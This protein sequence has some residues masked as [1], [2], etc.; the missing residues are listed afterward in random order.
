M[1]CHATHQSCISSR[2]VANVDAVLAKRRYPGIERL[3]AG[4][5]IERGRIASAMD[6]IPGRR[7]VL[8]GSGGRQGKF[9]IGII[10][11]R[12]AG[13]LALRQSQL[14][15]EDALAPRSAGPSLTPDLIFGLV[16]G[17]ILNFGGLTAITKK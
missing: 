7:E 13:R 11:S 15:K 1:L 9:R 5:G 4:G 14:S 17:S 16:V 10:R 8:F 3:K 12:C 2:L 6:E